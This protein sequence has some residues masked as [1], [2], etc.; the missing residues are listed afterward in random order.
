MI[1]E[2]APKR[3]SEQSRDMLDGGAAANFVRDLYP[4][5]ASRFE[6]HHRALINGAAATE[7]IPHSVG[8]TTGRPLYRLEDVALWA[9]Q[10]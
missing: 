9:D 4:E 6:A 7:D 1:V 8:I 2:S 10:S 3:V 5:K